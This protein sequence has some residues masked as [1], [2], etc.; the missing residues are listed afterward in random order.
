VGLKEGDVVHEREI[1]GQDAGEFGEGRTGEVNGG[2]LGLAFGGEAG[3]V[4]GQQGVGGGEGA[5]EVG[6]EVHGRS[7]RRVWNHSR[8]RASRSEMRG[9]MSDL[10]VLLM[11]RYIELAA[12]SC[13]VQ[14]R[15]EI[16]ATLL[17]APAANSKH[18]GH[19]PPP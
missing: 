1:G 13:I 17:H 9:P 3:K 10:G 18:V 2:V 15:G 16:D 6:V 11:P 5:D 14:F 7:F 8:M 4:A 19:K 12:I